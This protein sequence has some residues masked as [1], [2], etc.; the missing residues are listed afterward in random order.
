MQKNQ[1]TENDSQVFI[2]YGD[3]F[4]PGR[5]I[6]I[7]I[8]QQ[9]IGANGEP[10]KILDLGCG[11]G[12]LLAAILEKYP[13][14]KGYGLDASAKMLEKAAIRLNDKGKILHPISAK[15][16]EADWRKGNF[17]A[18]MSSLA[19]HHLDSMDK[20][21]LFKDLYSM[22]NPGGILAILDIIEPTRPVGFKV[23]AKF[24]DKAVEEKAIKRNNPKAL[25]KF[26]N[27]H[28]NYHAY[29]D[30]DPI[31]QPSSLLDQL[32][33][34]KSAGYKNVDVFWMNAGH[35]LFAGWK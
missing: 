6:Q 33:W 21:K 19:I 24:W 28:W 3:L 12:I 7:D 22:L 2:D 17:D 32:I 1:W 23:A 25:E 9:L 10:K 31:D 18:I 16:E 5:A 20:Q 34:L 11:E 30:L 27:D 29:P 14:T 35:A 4:I 15:L 26:R 13:D 8:I